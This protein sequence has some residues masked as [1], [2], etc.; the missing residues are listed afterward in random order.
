LRAKFAQRE[1]NVASLASRPP[2]IDTIDRF[3]GSAGA[4]LSRQPWLTAF[5]GV[6]QDVTFARSPDSWLVRDRTGDALPLAGPN[7]WTHDYP[8]LFTNGCRNYRAIVNEE[9]GEA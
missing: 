9:T 6:L 5:G 4:A 7:H 1:G 2:G 8:D 3:L